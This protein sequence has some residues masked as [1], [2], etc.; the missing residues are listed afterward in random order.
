[1]F[2]QNKQYCSE[3][4]RAKAAD[5]KHEEKRKEQMRAAFVEPVGLKTTYRTYDGVC[6][7]CGLPVPETV[8]ANNQWAATVD[9]IIPLSKG[10]LHKK[11]NC[12]L[13]HRLC[14]SIKLDTVDDFRI[15][16]IQKLRDEPGRW[17]EQLDDLWEQL[18]EEI[19]DTG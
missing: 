9:H 13:A 4:C 3:K 18:G 16:W 2:S 14:N 5:A 1:M 12:Q 15:D 8:E 19:L 11:S 7:I 10:G 17:N 6:G